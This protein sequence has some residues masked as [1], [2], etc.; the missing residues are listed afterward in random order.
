M[1]KIAL[2]LAL[3][4]PFSAFAQNQFHMGQYMVH[5]PFINP[6]SIGSYQ[7]PNAAIF[8]KNQWTGFAGAP[9][10]QGLN[11]NMP[12]ANKKSF[13]GITVIHDK[14]GISDATEI[15]GTYAYKIKTGIKSRLVFGLSTSLNLLQSNLA[16]LHIQD[17][18]DP[19]FSSNTK[20]FALPNFRFGTYFYMKKF[21]VGLAVPNI[22]E[23]KIVYNGQLEGKASF[24]FENLH[25]YLHSGYRWDLNDKTDLNTS[26]LVKE[27]SGS[28]LQVDLNAQV[29]FNKKFGVG[30]SYRTSKELLAM[31]SYYLIPELLLSYGYEFNFADIGR[32]SNGTHEILLSYTFSPASRP[33]V[34]IPR[35]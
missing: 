27:V 4:L 17:A 21:Y 31:A 29:L 14:V 5:Q 6:A 35:F 26:V 1:K 13:A 19:L 11:F 28:P 25:Y 32:Y 16:E 34:E 22:L 15:S 23:N 30:A 33:I 7:N 10:L 12:F 20:T 24:A 9:E 2:Y 3:V 18:N 8:Y